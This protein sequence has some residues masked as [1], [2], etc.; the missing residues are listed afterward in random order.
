[1]AS[2]IVDFPKDAALRAPADLRELT[3][4]FVARFSASSAATLLK[5]IDDLALAVDKLAALVQAMPQGDAR[6]HAEADLEALRAQI[7][8]ARALSARI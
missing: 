5:G 4:A 2:N 8:T 6:R 7:A 1:M 3:D